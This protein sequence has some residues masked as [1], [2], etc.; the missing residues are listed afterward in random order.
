M[1]LQIL[2]A[3][4][5]I[6]IAGI[7]VIGLFVIGIVLIATY[8]SIVHNERNNKPIRPRGITAWRKRSIMEKENK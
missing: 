3:I 5:A 2:A 4:L 7:V 1:M 6:T 8:A